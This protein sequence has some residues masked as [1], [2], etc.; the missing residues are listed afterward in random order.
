[1]WRY[2]VGGIAWPDSE[3]VING[4]SYKTTCVA[5][6]LFSG[7][8]IQKVSLNGGTFE[9]TPQAH[10]ISL[11]GSKSAAARG[12]KLELVINGCYLTSKVDIIVLN[13]NIKEDWNSYY[14]RFENGTLRTTGEGFSGAIGTGY[15]SPEGVNAIRNAVQRDDIKVFTKDSSINTTNE[16]TYKELIFKDGELISQ[17]DNVDDSEDNNQNEPTSP[18]TNEINSGENNTQQNEETDKEE[19]PNDTIENDTKLPQTGEENNAFVKWLSI[20]IPLGIFW[21]IAML[22]ID[23]EKKKM[24][25]R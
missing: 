15:S 8:A 1:M 3:V 20:A 11:N 23:R 5:L 13:P 18:N 6:S 9:S 24:T 2:V 17:T 16:R 21:L 22:L 12:E 14:I 7:G 25:K 4:G 10:C 19:L